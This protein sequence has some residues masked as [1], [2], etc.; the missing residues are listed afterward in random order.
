[1][2]QEHGEDY[3]GTVEKRKPILT[4]GFTKLLGRTPVQPIG[5]RRLAL[6]LGRID[7]LNFKG[8]KHTVYVAQQA[9]PD[10]TS[11]DEWISLY[12]AATGGNSDAVALIGGYSEP[13]INPAD[14]LS[15]ELEFPR[16]SDTEVPVVI[17]RACYEIAYALL[18]GKDPE[19]ELE[20]IARGSQAYSSVR[21]TY[22]RDQVPL[23]HVMNMIPSAAAWALLKPFLRDSNYVEF[24][25]AS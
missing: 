4:I 10:T 8:Q 17:E 12:I 14:E 2:E 15:Q 9:T 24:S 21:T 18:D 20:A 13:P 19:L 25:R 16:D 7:A 1:M 23:E 6:L 3:Y 5:S 11:N 22:S